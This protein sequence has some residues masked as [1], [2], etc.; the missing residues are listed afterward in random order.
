VPEPYPHSHAFP[1]HAV[2]KSTGAEVKKKGTDIMDEKYLETAL[3]LARL[4]GIAETLNPWEYME[5]GEFART[6]KAWTDEFMEAGNGDILK[7][8]ERKAG[9]KGQGAPSGPDGIPCP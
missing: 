8:F 7:F 2:K 1:P 5:N 6:I 9:R 3:I 4:Y